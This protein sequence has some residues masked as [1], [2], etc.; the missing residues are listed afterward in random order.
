M[1]M[2]DLTNVFLCRGF[3]FFS[4]INKD[5]QYLNLYISIDKRLYVVVN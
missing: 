1:F 5:A 2:N 4:L 3:F